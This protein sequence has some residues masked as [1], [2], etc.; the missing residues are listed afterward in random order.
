MQLDYNPMLKVQGRGAILQLFLATHFPL[1]P[2]TDYAAWWVRG[3]SD[4]VE[5]HLINEA[6]KPDFAAHVICDQRAP[7]CSSIANR[8]GITFHETDF[9]LMVGD[10][11]GERVLTPLKTYVRALGSSPAYHARMT[12]TSRVHANGGVVEAH[13]IG[14]AVL[15]KVPHCLEFRQNVQPRTPR[16]HGLRRT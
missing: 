14:R 6:D 12:A 4:K 11:K 13:R 3:H 15:A 9:Q 1:S 8:T 2:L 5:P 10:E 16:Q 7:E